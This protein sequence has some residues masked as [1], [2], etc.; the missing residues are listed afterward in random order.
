MFRKDLGKDV[1]TKRERQVNFA[2]CN[3]TKEALLVDAVKGLQI[4]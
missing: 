4:L 2:I 3:S 1:D